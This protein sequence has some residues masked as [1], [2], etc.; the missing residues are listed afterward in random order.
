MWIP[1][2]EE[3]SRL[4]FKACW[5]HQQK[6]HLC[7]PATEHCRRM[8]SCTFICVLGQIVVKSQALLVELV[9]HICTISYL[10][11]T[12]SMDDIITNQLRVLFHM[13]RNSV[14]NFH[15][16]SLGPRLLRLIIPYSM[17]CY[18]GWLSPGFTNHSSQHF[19]YWQCCISHMWTS[20]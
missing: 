20:T 12:A 13:L 16:S 10:L 1:G 3:L 8:T 9:M 7:T 17:Y 5:T 19:I 6:C 11:Q 2:K 14:K 15:S 18:V 4:F